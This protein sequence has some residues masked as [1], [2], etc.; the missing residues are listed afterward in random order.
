MFL[1]EVTVSRANVISVFVDSFEGINIDQC[2]EI[3]RH[4]ESSLDREAEDF[5]LQVSS[6]GLGQPFKVARQYVKNI[7]HEIEVTLLA[8]TKVK[9]TL[10]DATTEGFSI[11]TLVKEQAE[12]QKKKQLV[13]KT[14]FLRFDEIK[15]AKEIISFK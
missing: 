1:V 5:E 11:E 15:S 12:G 10:R 14:L 13:A 8:G 7:G 9:G 4:I 2:V 6:A 3:S